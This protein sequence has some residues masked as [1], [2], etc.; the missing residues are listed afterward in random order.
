[1][2]K[3]RRRAEQEVGLWARRACGAVAAALQPVI[4]NHAVPLALAQLHVRVRSMNK[5]RRW[6]E[7]DFGPR[8]G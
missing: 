2:N 4:R 6:A 1:M 7:Q 5:G 3:G 8:R